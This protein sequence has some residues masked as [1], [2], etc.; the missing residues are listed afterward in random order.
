MIS[1][2]RK[3]HRRKL[4]QRKRILPNPLDQEV[5]QDQI[6]TLM[7]EKL[8]LSQRKKLLPKKILPHPVLKI[9]KK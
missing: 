1:Q 2:S 5:T 8:R 3:L 4:L 6:L 9:M 7:L